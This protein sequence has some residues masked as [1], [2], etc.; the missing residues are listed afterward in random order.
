MLRS[1][2]IRLPWRLQRLLTRKSKSDSKRE[3]LRETKRD[4]KS[5]ESSLSKTQR[6]SKGKRNSLSKRGNSLTRSDKT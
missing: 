4:W 2:G 1:S 6:K 3:R 5:K